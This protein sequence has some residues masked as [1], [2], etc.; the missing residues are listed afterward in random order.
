MDSESTKSYK[1]K[2][3]SN[4]TDRTGSVERATSDEVVEEATVW[5]ESYQG[6]NALTDLPTEREN[7]CSTQEGPAQTWRLQTVWVSK[8]TEKWG[9]LDHHR[10]R[11]QEGLNSMALYRL[12]FRFFSKSR[13]KPLKPFGEMA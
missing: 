8:E 4:A 10:E 6:L 7:A 9:R 12:E 3:K 5:S 11:S 2:K 1:R 13:R